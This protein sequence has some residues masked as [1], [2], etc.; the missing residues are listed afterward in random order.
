MYLHSYVKLCIALVDFQTAQ[1]V[2][3][4]TGPFISPMQQEYSDL[5]KVMIESIATI[6]VT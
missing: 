1:L 6:V 3:D 5:F 4:D 2:T